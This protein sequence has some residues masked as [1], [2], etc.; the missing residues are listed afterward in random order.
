MNIIIHHPEPL[1]LHIP[2]NARPRSPSESQTISIVVV[3]RHNVIRR[4]QPHIVS[5]LK[6]KRHGGNTDRLHPRQIITSVK[7]SN[8]RRRRSQVFGGVSKR[9]PSGRVDCCLQARDG[10]AGVQD[11]ASVPVKIK[12]ECGRW[13]RGEQIAADANPCN[14]N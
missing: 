13:D 8:V 9:I 4:R 3:H 10:R 14:L 11:R 1:L 2:N 7:D 6:V 5:A 12:L